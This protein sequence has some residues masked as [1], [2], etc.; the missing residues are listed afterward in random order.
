MGGTIV[1]NASYEVLTSVPWQRAITLLVTGAAEV[2]EVDESRPIRSQKLWMAY[3][4]VI[5]LVRYVLVRLDRAIRKARTVSKRG[6][7]ER[8]KYVCAYCGGHGDTIDH[9]LPQSRGGPN[10]WTNL[11]AACKPCNNSKDDKLPEEAGMRLLW[12]PYAPDAFAEVQ[13]RIWELL[14]TA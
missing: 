1:L 8:D 6:V 7:L 4:K 5:R 13:E 2:I 12:E 9:V 11:V 10:T 3:P 14:Q